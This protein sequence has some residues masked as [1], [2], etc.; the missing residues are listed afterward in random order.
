MI[1]EIIIMIFGTILCLLSFLSVIAEARANKLVVEK[2]KE[3]EEKT[4][5]TEISASLNAN[6]IRNY[7]DIQ[8]KKNTS[9]KK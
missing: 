2:I 5:A 7:I 4:K 6:L 8:E 3:I 1:L 9:T